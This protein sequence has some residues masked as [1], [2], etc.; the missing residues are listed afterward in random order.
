[1]E[2]KAVSL[3]SIAESQRIPAKEF[4]KQYKDHLSNF[5]EWEQKNHA[6]EWLLFPN[7]IGQH[8]SIDEVDISNG[9]LY[10]VITNKEANGKKGALVALIHGT[11]V[12]DITVVLAKI[13]QELRNIVC[14]VTLDMSDSIN[15]AIRNMFPRAKR[16]TDRFHVQQLVSEAVQEVRIDLRRAAI[17]EEN[18]DIKQARKEKKKYY[19]TVFENGDTKKQLLARSRHLLFKPKTKWTTQQGERAKI[20][21]KEYPEIKKAYDISMLFRSFYEN[22]KAV[23]G[24]KEKLNEWYQKVEEENLDS[25]ITASESIRLHETTILNYFLNRSTN[26]GAES[27][28]A[29]LKGFRT[30]VR[31]IRDKKFFLF[32]ISKLYG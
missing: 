23:L 24:A 6:E 28:N 3:T 15:A 22:S 18:E 8:L 11:K 20:L 16:V 29:K 9:E 26:A 1:M 10:T 19:P 32:R 27:F 13:P 5:H 17:K 4:E 14:E 25:F 7:N 21:F 12:K 31:G 30:V 2:E